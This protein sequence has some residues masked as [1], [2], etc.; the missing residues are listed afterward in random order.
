MAK[1][2]ERAQHLRL[3]ETQLEM[4]ADGPMGTTSLSDDFEGK[5]EAAKAQLEMLHHKRE[6]LERQKRDLESLNERKKVFL[7]SQV[8]ITERLATALTHIDREIFEMRQETDDLDQTRK[9]FAEH[10]EKI[11]RL[12][13]ESWAKEKL[14]PNLDRAIAIL[15]QAEDEY[16]QAVEYFQDR[17]SGGGIFGGGKLKTRTTHTQQ[18]SSEFLTMLKNGL[19]FNLPVVLLGALALVVYYSKS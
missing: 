10:L 7:T 15:D 16:D 12:T 3:R 14:A 1:I 13:P 17:R 2:I 19:A 8:E 5:L 9:C 18:G 6:E 11:E 4:H